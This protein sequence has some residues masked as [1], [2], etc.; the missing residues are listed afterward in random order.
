LK[1]TTKVKKYLYENFQDKTDTEMA[2]DLGVTRQTVYA[3]RKK[4][5]LSKR[6][7]K[8][9]DSIDVLKTLNESAV[10]DTKG[11]TQEEK[12][13]HF[14]KKLRGNP[15]YKM[16]KES[17]T[18]EELAF[19]EAKYIEYS[20]SP[21]IE[22]LTAYEED[23]LHELTIT[24]IAKMRIQKMEHDEIANGDPPP[25]TSRNIRDKDETIL[26]LKKS[27][28]LERAQRLKRQ[29]DSAT[30]FINLVKEFNDA[31]IR[32]V[33]GREANAFNAYG[34]DCLND[35]IDEGFAFGI[36]KVDTKKYLDR[37]INGKEN[38]QEEEKEEK[39]KEKKPKKIKKDMGQ[40][41]KKF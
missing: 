26:K 11:M 41:K 17:L 28:D 37:G 3:Y 29:E 5:G 24:Q 23:D 9:K 38:K 27:L 22:T 25:D 30:N 35:L 18:E 8:E 19:Y 21:E 12:R 33:I 1:I 36:E 7:K 4:L 10:I 32:T 40:E 16:T 31:K 6:K 39:N 20:T 13:E 2:E 34:Q 14:L 15:R